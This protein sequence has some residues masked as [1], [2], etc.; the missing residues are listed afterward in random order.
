MSDITINYKGNAI[1]TMDASGTKTLLTDGKYCEDDIEVVYV[2]PGG[3]TPNLQAKTNINAT[4]FSQTITADEGYD[5]LSSVQINALYG[6][7]AQTIHPSTSDQT[8]ASG[9]YLT[10]AQ[11]IK[12]V[13]L[14]N[15]DAG[16][17]KKDVVVKVGDSTDDDC[18]TSV[19]GTYEGGG[20]VDWDGFAE[21]TWPTGDVVLGNTVTSLAGYR[22]ANMTGV[23]SV[24]GPE[25]LTIGVG[26]FQ[27]C[28]NLAV[29]HFQK[30]TTISGNYVFQKVNNSTVP[31]VI[32]LPAITTVNDDWCRGAYI[33]AIDLGP[34]LAQLKT[35]SFYAGTGVGIVILRS[36][37]IVPLANANAVDKLDSNTTIYIPKTLYDHLGDG[38]S[39]DYKA[40]TNWTTKAAV[41]QWAQIE[42]SIYETKYADGTT[43]P[44]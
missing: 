40:A 42:G 10:G 7:A 15:L 36:T 33:S 17:I 11:T 26:C 32:V 16:N 44:T 1:A 43:I 4:T 39:S 22:F 18:V 41:V 13:L 35:R 29:V 12:G 9:K 20:S 28:A 30:A 8:I 27:Y 21:G 23:T 38:S 14:T 25:V 3:G 34:N 2:K 5:G 24:I 31:C 6:Q 37:S 19:T